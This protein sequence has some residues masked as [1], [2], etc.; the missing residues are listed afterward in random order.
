VAIISV[1]GSIDTR[2]N[3][4]QAVSATPKRTHKAPVI[5]R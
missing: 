5:V 2:E 3:V 1:T 4:L